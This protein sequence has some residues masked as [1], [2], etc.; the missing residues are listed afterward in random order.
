MKETNI[1]PFPSEKISRVSN[2]EAAIHKKINLST[3]LTESTY[4]I[5]ESIR[6][7]YIEFHEFAYL[8]DELL[9]LFPLKDPEPRFEMEFFV[10][11][12]TAN[13]VILA[14]FWKH[15]ISERSATMDV[16]TYF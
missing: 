2:Y 8:P 3:Q 6:G 7:K 16:P 1:E 11:R 4:S 5:F 10:F 12:G 13:P 9:L 15:L 14:A